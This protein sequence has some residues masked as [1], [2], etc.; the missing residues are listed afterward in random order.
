ME[1]SLAKALSI[2]KISSGQ[3]S[4]RRWKKHRKDE[5]KGKGDHKKLAIEREKPVADSYL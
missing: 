5:R 4:E 1:I 3:A 2:I